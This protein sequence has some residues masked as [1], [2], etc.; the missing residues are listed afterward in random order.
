ML[1]TTHDSLELHGPAGSLSAPGPDP[2]LSKLA[3]LF[4]GECEGLGPKAAAQKHGYSPQR[5]FQLRRVFCEQGLPGLVDAKRGPK[6]NYRRTEE[7]VQQVI[8]YRFLDPEA[9]AE[10]IGQRLRQN[11]HSISTRT[12][13]RI[14]AEYGLQ[15]K[16]PQVSAHPQQP[17]PGAHPAHQSAGAGRSGRS[18]KS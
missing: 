12:V 15:K 7:V 4:E 11:G 13:G 8:R 3:M 10:V 14:I 5:Y 18:G 9:S 1:K 2:M 16:T 17:A 6:T